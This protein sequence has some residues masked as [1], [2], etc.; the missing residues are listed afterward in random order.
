[1]VWETGIEHQEQ[2]AKGEAVWKTTWSQEGIKH[3][4]E[5]LPQKQEGVQATLGQEKKHRRMVLRSPQANWTAAA[6]SQGD[7]HRGG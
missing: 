6:Q 3:G 2:G 1:M 4:P 5:R 7:Q